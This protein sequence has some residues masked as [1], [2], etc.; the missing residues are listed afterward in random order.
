[1]H[2]TKHSPNQLGNIQMADYRRDIENVPKYRKW[3]NQ[4]SKKKAL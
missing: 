4:E 1:M 2:E 3:S